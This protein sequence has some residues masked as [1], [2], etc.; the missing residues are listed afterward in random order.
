MFDFDEIFNVAF[1]VTEPVFQTVGTFDWPGEL[2]AH[3]GFLTGGHHFI[4][5]ADGDLHWSAASKVLDSQGVKHF[6]HP[7]SSDDCLFVVSE[8]DGEKAERLLV[9]YGGRIYHAPLDDLMFWR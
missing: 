2:Y 3:L 7:L 8:Q 6:G 4:L 9:K 1:Q 5:A